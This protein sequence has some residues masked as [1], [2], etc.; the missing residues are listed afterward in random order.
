MGKKSRKKKEEREAETSKAK[1]PRLSFGKRL[2]FHLV[3]LVLFF[4]V[5]ELLLAASGV[6]PVLVEE[7]PYVGFSSEIPLFVDMGG[8]RMRT[9]KNKLSL[10]N[11]Q[12]FERDKPAGTYRV[13]TLGGS[14]T[15]GRPFDDRTSWSGWLRTYLDRVDPDVDWEVINAG[16]I[17]YA[18]YR[19]AKVMEELVR[20]EPDL[21]VIYS[22]HNE[23]LE[24]RTYEGLIEEPEALTRTKLL[25]QKSRLW[26]VGEKLALRRREKARE[27]YEMT[28]E[29]E[30]LLDSSVGLDYYFRDEPFRRQVLDHYRFNLERMLNLARAAGAEVIV[31]N[32]PVNA[33]DF[34]PF[35]SQHQDGLSEAARE[36]HAALLDEARALLDAGDTGDAELAL[37]RAEEA[38][39]LDPLHADGHYVLSRA[40]QALE[41]F[42]DAGTAFARAVEED[43]CP[44]RALAATNEIIAETVAKRG[45]PFI[46]YRQLLRAEMRRI[47]GHE[48]L[49]DELFL[50][51]AHPTVEANG[52]LAR[53]LVETMTGLGIVDAGDGWRERHDEAVGSAVFERIDAE[54]QAEAY[55]NLSKLLIWAGKRREA[56]RYVE[57]AEETL[58][59]DWELAYNAALVH[60]D[61]GRLEEALASFEEAARRDPGRA[62]VHDQLGTTLARLGRF[63][64]AVAAGRK[65]VELEPGAASYWNNL[66]T[67]LNAA[68][69]PAAA[70]A[71]LR[72]AL[73]R[74]P[75]FAEAHNNLGKVHF[76]AGDLEAALR[77]FDRA[78]K[79]RPNYADARVNQGLVLGELGRLGDALTAFEAAL[80]LDPKLAAAHF[81]KGRALIARNEPAAAVAPLERALELGETRPEIDELLALALAT[82][83]QPERA[84]RALRRGLERHPQAPR[85]HQLHG[86]FLAQEGFFDQAA[87]AFRQAAALDPTFLQAQVDLGNLYMVRG[88]TADAIAVYQEAL[89]HHDE[90]DRLHHILATALLI[91]GQ[92]SEGREH[93]ERALELNPQNAAAAQDLAKLGG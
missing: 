20:Y 72:K 32:V 91:S 10:F 50:D 62:V 76:D 17:S 85:L 27:S 34:S 12:S 78:M 53:A 38:V 39:E 82:A 29:V 74:D 48:N 21:F 75:S 40:L 25:L 54:T 60:L 86:R 77:S 57:L 24:K 42:D 35:K 73:E 59:G 18:S 1:R 68:G 9:A 7:D 70:I 89:E 41:R 69:D 79:L 44:L 8:G 37:E 23:F 31:V 28:G 90:D 11:D 80:E 19:V 65:A 33:K 52:V 30:E 3:T 43:V 45:V 64:D 6:R 49:G 51:H 71:A 13:F 22:A 46:D 66:G 87:E 67:S 88:R 55:K 47:A 81:G 92:R 14:C 2:V 61:A 56:E 15:Y 63:D 83:E 93:L 4:G 16:G 5:L 84:W 58:G 26:A 36:R